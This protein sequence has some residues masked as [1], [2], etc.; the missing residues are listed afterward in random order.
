MNGRER[1]CRASIWN[2]AAVG[3]GRT[4]GLESVLLARI[5]E[6]V[7]VEAVSMT[8]SPIQYRPC[9]LPPPTLITISPSMSS[10]LGSKSGP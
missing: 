4:A 3:R 8:A 9:F 5:W 2:C 10:E 6:R 7:G 1:T